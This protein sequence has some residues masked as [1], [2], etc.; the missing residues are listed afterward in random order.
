MKKSTLIGIA[1]AAIIVI[2][3]VVAIA[4]TGH[5][6]QPNSVA[7]KPKPNNTHSSQVLPVKSNPI[8]NTSTT[9]GL[10]VTNAMVENNVN[11]ANNKPIPDRLQFSIKNSS[12]QIMSNLEVYYKM[13]DA[14]THQSEGY[15][16]KLKGLT[17]APGQT[18]TV[19]FDNGSGAG[20]YPANKYS[21]Y[22]TS[23]NAVNFSIEVSAPVFQPAMA[24]ARKGP[25]TGES[26]TG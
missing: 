1:V 19:F 18:K 24:H 25:G 21:I 8:K 10:S 11:P 20:H 26:L 17:I 2:G 9:P 16:Q 23:S 6:S 7:N 12:Q 15:F 3:L 13:T 4:L 22:R 14:K 5:N